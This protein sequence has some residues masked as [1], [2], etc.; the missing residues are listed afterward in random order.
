MKLEDIK[1]SQAFDLLN[2]FLEDEA[3]KPNG[4]ITIFQFKVW[5]ET[6][7]ISHL[8]D[9][10]FVLNAINRILDE[11]DLRDGWRDAT[12]GLFLG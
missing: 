4:S 8:R 3:T 1:I 9:N 12:R 10:V 2:E 7:R 5:K 6:K 11:V